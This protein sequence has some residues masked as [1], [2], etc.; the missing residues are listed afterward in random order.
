MKSEKAL[1]GQSNSEQN[2]QYWKDVYCKLQ[3]K[4][5][6]YSNKNKMALELTQTCRQIE[7]NASPKYE[8]K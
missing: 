6:S 4:L 7:Q 5:Q 3:G 2:N 8:Y 1:D